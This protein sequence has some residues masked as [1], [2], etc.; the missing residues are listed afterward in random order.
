MNVA[1]ASA[2]FIDHDRSHVDLI[3][4]AVPSQLHPEKPGL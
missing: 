1:V 4:I 2:L 3:A